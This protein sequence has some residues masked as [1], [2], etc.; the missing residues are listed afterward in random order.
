MPK[1]TDTQL[2]TLSA[3][4]ARADYSILPLPEK[5]KLSKHATNSFFERLIKKRLA[6]TQP[7]AAGAPV[8]RSDKAGQPMMLIITETGLQAL[9]AGPADPRRVA[10]A[11]ACSASLSKS[12]KTSHKEV[13]SIPLQQAARKPISRK[14]EKAGR[15]TG[16]SG[17]KQEKVAALLRRAGG[18]SIREMMKATG[19]QAHS[20]RGVISGA[21]RKKRALA[22]ISEK[23]KTG[24]RRYRIA[25]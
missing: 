19:W 16:S 18:A 4:T 2:A 1:L 6:K 24:D 7:A 23:S 25:K 10:S 13:S 22:I 20:V 17:S 15:S 11:D 12:E 21:L 3:A 5:L 8:W 14:A 9:V